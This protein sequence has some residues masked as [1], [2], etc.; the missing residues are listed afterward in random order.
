MPSITS[1]TS[2]LRQ[3]TRRYGHIRSSVTSRVCDAVLAC[4]GDT[5]VLACVCDTVVLAL[6]EYT[7]VAFELLFDRARSVS[8][9]IPVLV[10][11][12]RAANKSVLPG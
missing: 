5:V 4:V 9:R 3:G 11:R 10:C 1:I 7:Q 6:G 2:A 8:V 12:R